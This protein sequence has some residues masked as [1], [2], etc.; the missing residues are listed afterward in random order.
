MRLFITAAFGLLPASLLAQSP[1]Y[2]SAPSTRAT[3]VV[4]MTLA[5]T[6]AQRA[7]GRP[8]TLRIDYGQPHLRGRTLHTGDLVPLGTPW[9]LGANEATLLTTDLPLTIGGTQVPVGRYVLYALPES[10]GWTLILQQAPAAEGPVMLSAY[11]AGRDVARIPLRAG[12][13]TESVESLSIA[14][15]PATGTPTAQGVLS[16]AWDRLRLSVD[17][18]VR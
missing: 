18:A 3:A 10:G 13:A 16:I 9:R 14:L 1:A 7:I 2:V 6:A 15:V 4:S 12:S 17:W 5:D 11:D 8:A